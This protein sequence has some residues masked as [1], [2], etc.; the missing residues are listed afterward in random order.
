[1]YGARILSAG[2]NQSSSFDPHFNYVSMLLGSSGT[3]GGDND[4]FIDSAASPV[5]ITRN[6]NSM[7]GNFSP[8][9]SVWSTY[10]EATNS[11]S[12][13]AN[14]DAPKF[15]SNNF[16]IEFWVKPQTA[17]SNRYIVSDW[18]SDTGVGQWA[19]FRSATS[20]LRFSWNYTTGAD[21]LFIDT[22]ANSVPVGRWTHVAVVRN[23][24]SL[25]M[26]INGNVGASTTIGANVLNTGSTQQLLIGRANA[27]GTTSFGGYISNIRI[28]NGTAVYTST[29]IPPTSSLTAIP[30]TVL[31][32]CQAN[33]V[34]DASASNVAIVPNGSVWSR[35][36]SPFTTAGYSATTTG[37]SIYLDGT[38]DYL[39]FPNAA[40]T[41][42]TGDFTI[43]LWQYA[44]K[45]GLQVLATILTGP[46]WEL[47][48]VG[49]GQVYFYNGTT[50]YYTTAATSPAYLRCWNHIA[51]TY[52]AGTQALRIFVNGIMAFSGTVAKQWT[53]AANWQ[54]GRWS[55]GTG[56]DY[57]GFISDFRV[58]NGTA[59]YTANFTPP[60]A[61]LT[62]VTNTTRLFKFQN[63]N[64]FD[65]SANNTF[66]TVS[67]VVSST[68]QSKFG[69]SSISFN[70]SNS[71]LELP[72]DTAFNFSTGDFT[73]EYWMYWNAS[74]TARNIIETRS[75]DNTTPYTC[76][77]T[78]A[79]LP[80]F[81]DGSISRT[82]SVAVSV[83][84][85]THV[86]YSR[87][88]GVL[89]I[90]VNGVEGYNASF[91]NTVDAT[92]LILKIGGSSF[93]SPFFYN[94]YLDELRITSGHGRYLSSFTPPSLAF[95]TN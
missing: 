18:N 65:N 36:L 62:A 43:E 68:V 47:S 35:R 16:T 38:D 23:G 1:M 75:A 69:G 42:L 44:T 95:P 41:Q 5:T 11:F 27:A 55:A 93:G 58:I 94:G 85:W 74:G 32:T 73:I 22:V 49:N 9:G 86:A 51:V 24:T 81:F 80:Y 59:Q 30:N 64:V 33:R 78:S 2:G 7:Q 53:D 88:S 92:S 20:A 48:F 37:G 79:G 8:Y 77:V 6:G 45:T 29:F 60:S 57:G 34:Y 40:G 52:V 19:F 82:S 66:R 63:A 56:Y 76:S 83:N 46:V 71:Y 25:V 10:Y 21:N 54:I 13:I 70:G 39:T 4:T 87:T 61:P 50:S 89:R 67:T 15:S 91:T 26:Y 14:A 12:S 28:V 84:T 31:L 17:T 72:V 3:N 90:Y